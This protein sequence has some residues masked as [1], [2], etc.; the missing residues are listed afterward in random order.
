MKYEQNHWVIDD[1]LYESGKTGRQ[2][3]NEENLE[4]LPKN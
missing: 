1:I 4:F 2:H 3:L